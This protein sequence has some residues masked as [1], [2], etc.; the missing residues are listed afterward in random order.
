MYESSITESLH[1]MKIKIKKKKKK[2]KKKKMYIYI[3]NIYIF[4]FLIN[5]SIMDGLNIYI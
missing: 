5:E 4:P 2:K 1:Y 3:Y